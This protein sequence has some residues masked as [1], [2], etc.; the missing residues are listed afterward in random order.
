MENVKIKKM[1]WWRGQIIHQ[2]IHQCPEQNKMSKILLFILGNGNYW[3]T[4]SICLFQSSS[5]RSDKRRGARL[6]DFV[7]NHWKSKVTTIISNGGAAIPQW[8]RQRLP[9]CRPRFES[10]A[11]HQCFYQFKF[12]FCHAEKTKINKKGPGLAHLKKQ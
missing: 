4:I 12:D 9:S 5:R 6:I 3:F 11:Y 7:D 2:L 1:P 8:I 10:L